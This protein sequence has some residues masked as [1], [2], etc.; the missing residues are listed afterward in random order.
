MSTHK[1]VGHIVMN[2]NSI[3]TFKRFSQILRFYFL[4]IPLKRHKFPFSRIP[5]IPGGW[6]PHR[7]IE[8]SEYIQWSEWK[9]YFFT[10]VFTFNFTNI[11]NYIYYI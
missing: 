6:M 11:R 5:D 2:Y 7:L 4:I 9:I 3:K 10:A 1:K 8:F